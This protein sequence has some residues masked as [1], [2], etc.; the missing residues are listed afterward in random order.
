MTNV[1]TYDPVDTPPRDLRSIVADD[2]RRHAVA[3]DDFAREVCAQRARPCTE[4]ED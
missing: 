3:L 4:K 1:Q 2:H